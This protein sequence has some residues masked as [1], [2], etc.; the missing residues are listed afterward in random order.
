MRRVFFI[1][2]VSVVLS[3]VWSPAIFAAPTSTTVQEKA[4]NPSSATQQQ[5][6]FNAF[7][8]DAGA[9]LDEFESDPRI[10]AAKFIGYG[11]GL[12]GTLFLAYTIYG[13]VLWMTSA[14]NEDKVKKAKSIIFNG[15]IGLMLI[16]S[17]YGLT[18]TVTRLLQGYSDVPDGTPC[19]TPDY[20]PYQVDDPFYDSKMNDWYT[21]EGLPPC[22]DVPQ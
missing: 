19:I 1:T 17:A 15:T 12:L 21:V 8:G 7:T 13:G 4:E 3:L 16:L 20:S 18:R 2:I 10:Y 14:G 6:Q 5:N 11:L 9:N 22:E